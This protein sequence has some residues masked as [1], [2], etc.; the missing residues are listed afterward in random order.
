M[1]ADSSFIACLRKPAR[2]NTGTSIQAA[3]AMAAAAFFM[4]GTGPVPIPSRSRRGESPC[5][6]FYRHRY[7]ETRIPETG[8]PAR[9]ASHRRVPGGT[10]T[11]RRGNR[12][13]FNELEALHLAKERHRDL[14]E[15]AQRMRT[16]GAV[17]L[18]DRRR[19][20]LLGI[21]AGMLGS[22]LVTIGR[23]MQE[24]A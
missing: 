21:A 20:S 19:K 18:R 12:M 15:Q 7:P 23:K 10:G 6:F 11:G 22:Q 16:A 13:Y 4:A 24:L 8:M 14:L 9:A 3:V 2:V 1:S 17:R 5:G